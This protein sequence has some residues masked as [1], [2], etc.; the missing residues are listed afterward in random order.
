MLGEHGSEIR[1]AGI[2]MSNFGGSSRLTGDLQQN[3][4]Y[5]VGYGTLQNE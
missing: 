4:D 1:S 2:V 3:Q 5:I